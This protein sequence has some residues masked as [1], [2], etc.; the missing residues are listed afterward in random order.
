MQKENKI[1]KRFIPIDVDLFNNPKYHTLSN[2]AKLVYSVYSSRFRISFYHYLEEDYTYY[3]A[4]KGLF[5]YF[6]NED[7]ARILNVSTR[8][9]TNY[10]RELLEFGLIEV[11]DTK[12]NGHRIYV[13]DVEPTPIDL[14]K[15][16]LAMPYFVIDEEESSS[17]E[18]ENDS[19]V[20]ENFSNVKAKKILLSNEKLKIKNI[21]YDSGTGYIPNNNSTQ[22]Q[23]N[24]SLRDLSVESIGNRIKN[25]ISTPVFAKIKMLAQNSYEKIKFYTDTIFK[26]KSQVM[27]R[28]L[29]NPNWL[30]RQEFQE[31]TRFESN[32]FLT[33]G[34]EKS[35]L[36]LAEIMYKSDNE[37]R[38]EER[39]SYVYLRNG[40]AN[41]T[42][43]YLLDN[44]EFS[45]DER[46]QI[47]QALAF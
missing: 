36:K 47:T 19:V 22:P 4:E 39:L 34:L 24:S 7:L 29:N 27:S 3:D 46:Y 1:P 25:Q 42:K 11:Q 26:A 8:S 37:I 23:T 15:E 2:G 35:L 30:Y 45:D 6:A 10:K 44:F 41:S 33:D 38:S 13:K 16:E 32:L 14:G 43:K 28:L 21:T 20:M 9:I 12:N 5:I 18:T 31:A 40:L 17:K